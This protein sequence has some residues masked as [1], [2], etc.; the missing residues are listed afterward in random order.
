MPQK[1]LVTGGFGYVGSRLT[2]HLLGLGH[3]VRVIALM[4]YTNAGLEALIA[5]KSYAQSQSRFDLVE[6]DI[7]D[8]KTVEKAVKRIDT[9]T[10][11]PAISNDPTGDLDE[12]LTRQ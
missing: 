7:R 12:V 9:I 8:P 5:D 1:I 6:G 2:P 3:H 4:L 11:L 10:H